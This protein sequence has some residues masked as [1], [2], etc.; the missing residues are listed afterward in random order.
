MQIRSAARLW[1][2]E[3]C[4]DR[5]LSETGFNANK[6][7]LLTSRNTLH[8][9]EF[10]LCQQLPAHTDL[11]VCEVR[12]LASQLLRQQLRATAMPQPATSKIVLQLKRD[13]EIFLYRALAHICPRNR[14]LSLQTHHHK[15]AS[16]RASVRRLKASSRHC[17]QASVARSI[18][19]T[20]CRAACELNASDR[21]GMSVPD[22]GSEDLARATLAPLHHS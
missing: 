19:S 5:R 6:L 7:S 17:G 18:A 4:E 12:H 11:Y 21:M 8:H 16:S 15:S 14:P 22:A 1:A 10:G 3:D 2:C 9:Y 13:H 20:C